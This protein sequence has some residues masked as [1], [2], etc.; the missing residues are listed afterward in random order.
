M[1]IRVPIR[2]DGKFEPDETFTV[3]LSAPSEGSTLEEGAESATGTILNDDLM[4]TLSVADV[5]I[6]EGQVGRPNAVFTVTL[7]N[8]TSETVTVLVGTAEGTA[9]ATTDY[10]TTNQTLTFTPGDLSRTFT[11]PIVA[12]SVDEPDETFFVRLTSPTGATL[13]RPEAVGTIRNDDTRITVDDATVVEGNSG[14]TDMIFT[15]R[16]NQP[17][18]RATSVDFATADDTAVSSGD[19]PD[20]I[21]TSG[22]VTFEVGEQTRTVSIHPGRSARRDQRALLPESFR[23][24]KLHD[25]R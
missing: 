11:V 1:Q 17:A 6:A 15:L 12:D 13:G 16:L 23:C 19:A 4:P 20:Y 2:G 25:Q 18:A 22:T 9:T 14:T 5:S 8:P 21:A 3:T 24:P 7:S 10:T